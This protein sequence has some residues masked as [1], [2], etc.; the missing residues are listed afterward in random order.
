MEITFD[1]SREDYWR[2]NRLTQLK[3]WRPRRLLACAAVLVVAL[4]LVARVGRVPPLVLVAPG[5]GLWSLYIVVAYT[6]ARRYV[7]RLPT[8]GGGVV[9]RHT[10]GIG[11]DGV[12]DRTD[13]TDERVTW[14][15]LQS[16][17]Q[18]RELLIMPL[19]R[20]Q[21]VLIPTRAFANQGELARFVEMVEAFRRND[22]DPTPEHGAA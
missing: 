19:D 3:A 9:G 1:L 2:Y 6:L 22:V 11:P 20:S 15:G 13:V 21:A 10:I 14:R 7:M 5:V 12:R 17:V 18:D 16:V 4:V 8:E